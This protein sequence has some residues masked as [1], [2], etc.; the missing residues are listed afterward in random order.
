MQ[1]KTPQLQFPAPKPTQPI[2]APPQTPKI[3]AKK[4][5]KVPQIVVLMEKDGCLHDGKSF[6]DTLAPIKD[7][8]KYHI[9]RTSKGYRLFPSDVDVH[10]LLSAE[11]AGKAQHTT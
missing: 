9:S 5:P 6:N 11:L 2:P 4:P 7:K 8:A 1:E 10:K 3:S